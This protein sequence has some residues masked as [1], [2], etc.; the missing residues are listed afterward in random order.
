[1]KHIKG[2]KVVIRRDL[3]TTEKYDDLICKKSMKKYLGMEV[4]IDKVINN[5]CYLIKEDDNKHY[6]SDSMF[7]YKV[8][9][10]VI[11][12]FGNGEILAISNNEVLPYLVGIKVYKEGHSG[13]YYERIYKHLIIS[14]GYKNNCWWFSHEDIRG[15]N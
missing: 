2:E 13:G 3:I 7:Q 15:I 5:N 8:G 10:K 4:T 1:M 14:K 9:D 11:T 6:W 12:E